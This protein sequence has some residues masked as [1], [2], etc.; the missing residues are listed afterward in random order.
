MRPQ[1]EFGAGSYLSSARAPGSLSQWH[2]PAAS[3]VM[4]ACAIRLSARACDG[5]WC[6][7]GCMRAVM[8]RSD[9]PG[10]QGSGIPAGIGADSGK[11]RLWTGI[12]GI[13]ESGTAG[14]CSA[15]SREILRVLGRYSGCS[16]RYVNLIEFLIRASV[17]RPTTVC[18]S[19]SGGLL[20]TGPAG[21]GGSG[22]WPGR[23]GGSGQPT[24]KRKYSYVYR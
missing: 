13:R 2:G 16:H 8:R 12:P 21:P 1:L 18:Q 20:P 23:P 3:G 9:A 11:F 6:G 4:R 22:H 24:P 7:P 10:T 17:V 19:F 5:A 15:P 14:G